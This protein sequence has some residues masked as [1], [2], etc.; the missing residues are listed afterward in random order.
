MRLSLAWIGSLRGRE[1][2]DGVA[3]RTETLF[4]HDDDREWVRLV[5]SIEHTWTFEFDDHGDLSARE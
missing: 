5:S 1:W 3:S 2:R 4:R